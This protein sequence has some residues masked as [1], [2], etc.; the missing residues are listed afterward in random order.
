MKLA[1]DLAEFSLADLVQ[2]AGLAGRTCGIKILAAE[3]NGTLFLEG[4]EVVGAVYENLA[5]FDAFVALMTAHAGHFQVENGAQAP[6][7]NLQGNVQRLLLEANSRIEAGVVP[8]PR[9]KAMPAAA[10]LPSPP[11]PAPARRSRWFVAGAAALLLLAAVSWLA[12]ARHDLATNGPDSERPGRP[13]RAAARAEAATPAVEATQLG[14]AGDA[15]PALVS[16]TPPTTPD[17]ASGLKPT[18]VC[19][20]RIDATGKVAEAKIYRSR[21]D[22]AAFEEAALDAVQKYRFT[23]G[24]KAG[25]TVPVWMS[26]PVTFR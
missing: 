11:M 12:F 23:P 19:R 24:R 18:I 25:T 9:R 7:R 14:G 3:G 16:G 13:E 26:W 2:V 6:E 4:G 5:G 15:L 20:L 10:P 22:L 8:R 21:M 17:P 1:G